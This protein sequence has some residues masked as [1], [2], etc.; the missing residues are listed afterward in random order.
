VDSE[1]F[2]QSGHR[3]TAQR[4]LVLKILEEGSGHLARNDIYER[5][6]LQL[7]MVNRST[8][9]RTLDILEELGVVRHV[10]DGEGATRYHR[11]EDPL[12]LHLYCHSCHHL[13]EIGNLPVSEPLL[14]LL[15]EKYGFVADLTHF[16]IAGLCAGCFETE[17][18]TPDP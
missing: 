4:D 15:K 14:Q 17:E 16:P 13:I 12:H 7:P 18:T 9:Y 10:H 5:I 1:I 11:A 8:I 3:L 2:R 6:H